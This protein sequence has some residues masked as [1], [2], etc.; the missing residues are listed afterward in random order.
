[1]KELRAYGFVLM[2]IIF[3]LVWSGGCYGPVGNSAIPARKTLQSATPTSALI[4]FD[5]P[6]GVSG[7][8]HTGGTWTT[9]P[10]NT[11]VYDP[12]D[13]RHAGGADELRAAVLLPERGREHD[14]VGVPDGDGGE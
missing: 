6:D 14:R 9:R 5:V 10:L 8:P 1:M 3:G 13:A 7:G 4:T 11:E 12:A 2:G